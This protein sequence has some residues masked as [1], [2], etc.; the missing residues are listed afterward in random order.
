VTKREPT[1]SE[2]FRGLT[3]APAPSIVL[4]PCRFCR[5]EGDYLDVLQ[6]RLGGAFM[7]CFA[8]CRECQAQGPTATTIVQAVAYWNKG[9]T[10]DERPVGRTE[11]RKLGEGERPSGRVEGKS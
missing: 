8:Y 2:K 6:S 4:A 7:K 9:F 11:L 3:E 1:E 10:D 5:A